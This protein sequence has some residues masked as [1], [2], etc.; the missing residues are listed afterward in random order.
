MT[1]QTPQLP[2]TMN[3]GDSL[4]GIGATPDRNQV[5]YSVSSPSIM[6]QQTSAV[7]VQQQQQRLSAASLQQ[8]QQQQQSG[9]A[10]PLGHSPGIVSQQSIGN[11]SYSNG[12]HYSDISDS[13][14]P[15][16]D[17][18]HGRSRHGNPHRRKQI[19]DVGQQGEQL[20]GRGLPTLDHTALSQMFD[21]VNNNMKEGATTLDPSKQLANIDPDLM[22]AAK[23]SGYNQLSSTIMQLFQVQT[24]VLL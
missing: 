14:D 19:Q 17:G 5:V 15:Y 22:E 24:V 23:A 9:F 8:H 10:M 13:E 6:Q 12:S 7:S 2:V 11:R 18:H 20:Q 3:T 21:N 4:Q 1:T 16:H